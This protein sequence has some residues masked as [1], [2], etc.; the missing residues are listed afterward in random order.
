MHNGWVK[1]HRKLLQNPIA[2]RPA[3]AW[4]WITLLIKANHRQTKI[5][6]NGKET[7][8]SP[9]SLLTGRDKLAKETGIPAT[10]IERILNFLEKEGKIGQQ[11]TNKFRIIKVKNWGQYQNVDNQWTSS[12]HPVDTDKNEKNDKNIYNEKF[13]KNKRGTIVNTSNGPISLKEYLKK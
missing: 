1:I 10:T 13:K 3:Y 5:I 4:L 7:Q 6:F 8:L 12:G 9:G 11:K 2:R